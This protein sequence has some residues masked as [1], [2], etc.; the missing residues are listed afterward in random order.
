[1]GRIKAMTLDLGGAGLDCVRFGAGDR[2]LVMLPGLSLQGVRGAAL[3]LAYM[4]RAFARDYT[5]YILDKRVKVPEG[6]TIRDLAFDA[7]QAMGL[8]GLGGADVWGVSQGG[9]IAQRLAI[10]YPQ[11][12]HKLVLGVTAARP[13]AAM[14]AAVGQWVSLAQRG[15]YAGLVLDMLGRMYSEPYIQRRRWVLGLLARVGRAKDFTRFIR[16]AKACL[17]CDTYP[18]LRK[19]TCPVFVMGG[20][21]DKVLTGRASEE[22]AG[23]LGCGVKLYDG[24]GHAAYEEAPDFNRQVLRFLRGG[25]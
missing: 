22:I 4:Y 23:A 24:L 6:V 20:R 1:M 11:R 15:D 7:E 10:E 3:P 16:L 2:Q 5:V 18:E 14:E 8:L 9:M 25:G 21:E 13:N 12:V 19:I 17:T